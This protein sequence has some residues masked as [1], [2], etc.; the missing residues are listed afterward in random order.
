MKQFGLIGYPLSHSWSEKFFT[1][2]FRTA[3]LS[4]HS[5]HLFPLPHL[6]EFPRF[7]HTHPNLTGFN[8][9]IPYKERIIPF[10]DH[11]DRRAEEIGAVNTVILKPGNG[12]RILTG[13]N[14][15][16]DGFRDSAD[17]S[18]HSQ[19][20]ILG[21]GGAAKAVCFA[22]KGLGITPILVS[23]NPA[24]PGIIGYKNLNLKLLR[25]VYLIINTT[26]C[27]MS[28]ET[29][30]F[31]T[32]PYH[33]LT[34]RHFLYDLIYNPEETLFLKKGAEYGAKTQSGYTMLLLQAEFAYALFTKSGS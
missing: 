20:L 19:A 15:D 27:G 34:P 18:G 2:K 11:L 24:G 12:K 33:L 31:P 8:V 25:E 3:G 10:L 23:R 9:T 5:Y 21:T 26:P 30:S 1:D 28:P 13:Y 6:E 16:A 22:L 7:I 29:G 17:F 14:T 32:L 4:D